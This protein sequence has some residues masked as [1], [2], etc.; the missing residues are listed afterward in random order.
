MMTKIK[1]VLCLFFAISLSSCSQKEA[2]LSNEAYFFSLKNYFEEEAERLTNQHAL[3]LKEVKRNAEF[4][5]KEIEIQDWKK[6]FGL[7]IESD[8][9]K[10]SW[11]DSY[12]ETTY[13]NSSGERDT[14]IYRSLDPKLRTQEIM[15][16]R[17]NKQIREIAIKNN[18]KNYL[19]NSVEELKYYPDSLYEIN[20]KQDVIILGSNDYHISGHFR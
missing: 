7:F 1:I 5:E 18:T 4:E 19:Y 11:K 6:E 12:Q 16:V 2:E 3:V 14:L 8:I 15:I 13:K 17:D 10:L 9:N 20:K